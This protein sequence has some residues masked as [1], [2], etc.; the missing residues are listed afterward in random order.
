MLKTSAGGQSLFTRINELPPLAVEPGL[1]NLPGPAG[2]WRRGGVH[3]RPV[4]KLWYLAG[5]VERI[6]LA[7]GEA[8]VEDDVAVGIERIGVDRY[9]RML[10]GCCDAAAEVNALGVPDDGQ[11]RRD[12]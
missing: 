1:H 11:L 5:I 6:V 3:N 10:A 9:K 8:G 2:I 12:L 4:R 7:P